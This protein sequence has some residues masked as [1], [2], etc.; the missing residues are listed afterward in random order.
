MAIIK[1]KELIGTSEKGFKDALQNVVNQ[2]CS[3]KKNVTGAKV[4]G[5]TV[6]IKDG[7]IAEYKVN[8]KVAYRWEEGLH[9]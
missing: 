5:Q 2:A 7:K 8:V 1:V 6:E 3:Q 4:I 9:K